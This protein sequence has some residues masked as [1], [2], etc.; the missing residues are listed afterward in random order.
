MLVRRR[1]VV[2]GAALSAPLA[3]WAEATSASAGP[4]APS[5]VA[6]AWQRIALRTIFLD[7]GSPPPIGVHPLAFT[8]LAVDAAVRATHGMGANA[9]RAAVASAA[10]D[11]LVRYY[12]AFS[13]QL[14]ADL[15]A[16]LARVPNVAAKAKGVRIG[17][18]AAAAM[19]AS[20]AG[21]GYLDASRVYSKP[22]GIGVWQPPTGGVMAAAWVGFLRPVVSIA[23]V[24]LDGPDAVGT[25]AYRAH[26]DEVR[27]LGSATSTM[28]TAWQT[29]TA[30]FLNYITPLQYRDALCRHLDAEPLSLAATTH[31]FARLDAATSTS[32]IAAWRLKFDVG[33]WRPFQA[34]HIADDGDT[35]TVQDAAWAP[36]IP[37]PAYSDYVSGH[38]SVTA[39]FAETLRAM[40]GNDV[41]L[42][43]RNPVMGLERTYTLDGLEHDAFHARIWGGL[44]FRD[45]MEDGYDLGH[46]TARAVAAVMG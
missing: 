40:L 34:I 6:V 35:M 30:Q 7:G 37:N 2:L 3:V 28:R 22:P 36:L 8:S 41:R 12:G 18:A 13:G 38:A 5:S 19:I 33:F 23:P 21:D 4:A 42:A 15:A 44:H 20:R 29:Q 25:P 24:V 39:P 27:L 10:H 16:S 45:A 26:Y 11:V 17:K 32:V 46:R 1:T 43:L 31:L 9:A 14:D